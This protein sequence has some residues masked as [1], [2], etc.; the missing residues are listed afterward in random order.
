VSRHCLTH[1]KTMSL[2]HPR[3]TTTW[4][5]VCARGT[6]TARYEVHTAAL[7]NI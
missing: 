5:A 3:N 7:L 2:T 1:R 6:I 4:P